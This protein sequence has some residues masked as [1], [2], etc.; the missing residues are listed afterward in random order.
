MTPL[1]PWRP[2]SLS[3]S[4]IL[5]FWATYT[6]TS[7]LTPGAQLV[8]VVAG[9]HPD[10][11]DLAVLAVRHLQRGVA[12][13]ARLLTEDRAEQAL[14]R[15]QLGLALRRDL[16]DQDVAG[17]HLGADAD[18]AA[19][20]EVG[21]HLLG[22][23]RDVPGDLLGA[24]LGVAGVDLVLLDVDRR[25]HVVLHEALR[26]DDR[27]LVVVAL[28]RH[29]RH[30]QVLAQRHL[31]VLGARPVGEHLAHLDPRALVHDRLLVGAGALVAAAELVQPVGLA[32]A[33]VGH[34]RDEVGAQLL[35]DT[36][37]L[38]D[39]HVTGVDRGAQLHA[40]ADQRRLGAQQRHRLALHVGAHQRAVGVVVLE[41]RDHRGGD[42]H[43]LPRRDV[44]VVD[45]RRRDVVDLAA[46]AAD[47]DA[48]LLEASRR[49]SAARW[50][51]R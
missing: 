19:L 14:L 10:A 33:V 4:W 46:L 21:Q 3:P 27:V 17:L 9:E 38:G 49:R 20:V 48:L 35:D 36:G 8:L 40:G 37:L 43:H 30:E 28:P 51:A 47:Q 31:A 23:V 5:R 44:D 7:S 26:E 18:D 29:D 34:D 12:H 2:A 32:G 13:L 41:E 11:D 45:A 22:D 25:E 50:P 42:R 1:L 15:G 24:Q 16:A 6:R 39:D